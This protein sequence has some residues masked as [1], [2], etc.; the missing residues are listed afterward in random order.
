MG[1]NC[2][3][4]DLHCEVSSCYDAGLPL[5]G[6]A[7][8]KKWCFSFANVTDYSATRSCLGSEYH[9]ILALVSLALLILGAIWKY[10]AIRKSM[11]SML[12]HRY[13]GNQHTFLGLLLNG[14]LRF[15]SFFVPVI[16]C[17]F[18]FALAVLVKGVLTQSR[19]YTCSDAYAIKIEED[20]ASA[21]MLQQWNT[22]ETISTPSVGVYKELF[23]QGQIN[24]NS[25]RRAY[26][27][28]NHSFEQPSTHGYWEDSNVTFTDVNSAF[29]KAR[30]RMGVFGYQRECG[31]CIGNPLP[32]MDVDREG[33]CVGDLLVPRGEQEQGYANLLFPIEFLIGWLFLVTDRQSFMKTCFGPLWTRSLSSSLRIFLVIVTMGASVSCL[34][35]GLYLNSIQ[36]WNAHFTQ[37]GDIPI[38]WQGEGVSRFR[39][40]VDRTDRSITN[41]EFCYSVFLDVGIAYGLE[42]LQLTLMFFFEPRCRHADYQGPFLRREGYHS[43]IFINGCDCTEICLYIISAVLMAVL[44]LLMD[45]WLPDF[46]EVSFGCLS[47]IVL[48]LLAVFLKR[49][50]NREKAEDA[51][52]DNLDKSVQSVVKAPTGNKL[53]L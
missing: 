36:P 35:L 18:L 42:L 26:Q 47:W 21:S 15:E 28:F 17:F 51:S 1:G 53:V 40:L 11:H 39:L 12:F 22:S 29:R 52:N 6:E 34:V 41:S 19:C 13:I 49:L 14:G 46:V 5:R 10:T 32:E 20:L 8:C 23:N 45:A 43:D 48:I 27:Q 33:Q 31:P 37:K 16:E 50:G 3:S 25:T 24:T 30:C 7:D 38:M 9:V 2:E 4:C 44:G